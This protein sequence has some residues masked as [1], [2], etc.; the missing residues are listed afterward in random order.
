MKVFIIGFMLYVISFMRVI[1]IKKHVLIILL[2]LEFL[3]L[4]GYVIIKSCILFSTN[5]DFILI[6][7]LL[8]GVVEGV[9][10]LGLLVFY[11]RVNGEDILFEIRND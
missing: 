1:L 5:V 4:G 8:I 6:Y 11:L 7:F 2:Y 10:G 3:F 9:I